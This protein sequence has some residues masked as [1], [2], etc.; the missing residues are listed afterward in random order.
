ML[1]FSVPEIYLNLSLLNFVCLIPIGQINK[2]SFLCFDGKLN[3]NRGVTFKWHTYTQ[4][5]KIRNLGTSYC[6]WIQM[7][8]WLLP[9]FMLQNKMITQKYSSPTRCEPRDSLETYSTRIKTSSD[10]RINKRHVLRSFNLYIY[11]IKVMR[12]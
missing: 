8:S 7:I 2:T 10:I 12:K 5:D 4:I 11:N 9:L 6:K 1:V 3:L